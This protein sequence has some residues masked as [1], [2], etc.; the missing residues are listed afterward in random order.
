MNI[1][2]KIKQVLKWIHVNLFMSDF[3]RHRRRGGMNITNPYVLESIGGVHKIN[4]NGV[5]KMVI[6]KKT[7]GN[8][9]MI[10][11]ADFS[12]DD[13]GKVVVDKSSIEWEGEKS[14]TMHEEKIK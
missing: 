2:Q 5:K 9:G 10:G 4:K 8:S 7:D 6:R 12:F 3:E 11:W 14:Y 1:M 13:N